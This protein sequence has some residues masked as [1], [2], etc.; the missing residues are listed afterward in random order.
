MQNLQG[1]RVLV[2]GL[3]RS[4][5]A[6]A[7]FLHRRGAV[8]T[9]SDSRPP[10]FFAAEIPELLSRKFGI[11][12]GQHGAETFL[13]QDVIIA[14]PGVPWDLEALANARE[15]R[16]PVVAEV[17]AASWFLKGRLVGVTGSNGKTTTTTLIGRMLEG[18]GFPVFVGGNIGVPLISAV[19]QATE[20]TISVAELSSFQLEGTESLHPQVAVV[21]NMTPNHLD[22]HP[23][24]EAYVEAKAR[25]LRNQTEDDYAVLNADDTAAAG[26][27]ERT[28]ARKLFF[29]RTQ[30]LP[31]GLLVSEGK[32]VY[33]VGHLQR[34]LFSPAD[35]KL[36]GAFN[37]ENVLAASAV[38]CVLGADFDGLARAVREFRGV[39]HRLE[40]AGDV[41][42]VE[43]Y[44][45]S[46]ATS[47]GATLKALGAFEQGVHLILGGQDKGAP[48]APLVPFIKSRVREVLLI[49]AAADRI[50]QELASPL[51]GMVELVQAGDLETAVRRAFS[52]ARP[53][54]VILLSPACASFDQFHD[55]E[56]RGRK[57]KELVEALARE[58]Q[59]AKARRFR[60]EPPPSPPEIRT[61]ASSLAGMLETRPAPDEA[62]APV[63]AHAG[64]SNATKPPHKA[65]TSEGL[66]E[67]T[68]QVQAT[69]A[70]AP[71]TEPPPPEP[72]AVSGKQEEVAVTASSDAFQHL[73]ATRLALEEHEPPRPQP[74]VQPERI[75]VYEVE[76][77]EYAPLDLPGDTSIDDVALERGPELER[78]PGSS[79]RGLLPGEPLM[80]EVPAGG[81]VSATDAAGTGQKQPVS[82]SLSGFAG[83]GAGDVLLA[84]SGN[85]TGS[86]AAPKPMPKRERARR[87]K[88]R[89]GTA[90]DEPEKQPNGGGGSQEKLPGI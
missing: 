80:F 30:E 55:F 29:S 82:P 23:S 62:E 77:E 64:E 6:A 24:F 88:R 17:E 5:R 14:S 57:F 85:D 60:L 46:K 3:A 47:V 11:E 53:S 75:Y 59:A 41:L 69:E 21:L 8:V 83:Q 49:G 26:L 40:H 52:K 45:D 66:E 12:F 87:G 2:V 35:V 79:P 27:A 54:E 20:E 48:Y 71:D 42:G 19:E 58:G 33:R 56:D 18:S 65:A 25:I 43:F 70:Q 36:R 68:P 39:E 63:P 67:I 31:E 78:E 51:A 86:E 81:Q 74:Q 7:E 44:N 50:E 61:R 73:T 15:G 28:G 37:L 16:I 90:P 1:K 9:V 72:P 89:A 38:A 22:R 10:W 13:R 84:K 34:E 4:G 32:V 76:A